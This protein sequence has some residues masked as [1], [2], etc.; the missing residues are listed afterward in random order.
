MTTGNGRW[1]RYGKAGAAAAFVTAVVVGAANLD[2]FLS[3]AERIFGSGG[4]DETT[5]PYETPPTTTT[6]AASPPATAAPQPE[7]PPATEETIQQPDTTVTPRTTT[8]VP[9]AAPTRAGPLI[10]T[11]QMG[12]SGK[13]GPSEY[14]A[15][16]TP[17]ANVDV[18]DDIGQLSNGCY[19]SWVLTREG[20]EVKKVRNGRCTSG[21][22][23]MFNFD[24]SLDSPGGYRLSVNIVTDAGQ[25][26]SGFV[27]F[28]VS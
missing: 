18:Y 13:I 4:S 2:G 1:A 25:T 8:A 6:G 28:T 14:R 9:A 15:G 16:A 17:G 22:I 26:G 12:S 23:T 21:G 11:I 5:T 19:P 20:A 10:V 27:D 3:M 24:D 7:P